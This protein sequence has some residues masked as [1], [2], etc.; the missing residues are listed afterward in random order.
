MTFIVFLVM[1]SFLFHSGKIVQQ[2]RT[3]AESPQAFKILSCSLHFR[4]K[5][6]SIKYVTL[7]REEGSKV[8]L[9]EG[10]EIS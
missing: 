1:Y 4:G 2:P 9:K 8:V 7:H 6:P 10:R 5:G 3:T